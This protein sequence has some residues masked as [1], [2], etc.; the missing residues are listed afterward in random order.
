MN[1]KKLA[2]SI[3]FL[4]FTLLPITIYSVLP[5]PSENRLLD[6]INITVVWWVIVSIIFFLLLSS[7]KL[8]TNKSDRSTLFVIKIYLFW[9]I[10]SMIRGCFIAENYWDWK[11]L[12]LNSQG[13]FAA[14]FAYISC[15]ILMVQTLLRFYV[16][17]VAPLFIIFIPLL[18]NSAY[19]FYLIPFS[20]FLLFLPA[21]TLRWKIIILT[22]AIMVI[23]SDLTARST[24]IRFIVPIILSPIFYLKLLIPNTLLD[25]ARKLLLILPIVLFILAAT[26]TF[27]IFKMD[28][29]IEG[30]YEV[31][32]L[33][34]A[35]WQDSGNLK[36]DT[37]TL[38]YTEVFKSAEKNNSWLIG[39][40]L[41][42]GNESLAFGLNDETGRGERN[43]NE[44]SI[45][46]IFTWTGLVG[47]F[48]YF[49]AFYKASYL[50]INR[51]NNIYVKILGL[52]V[53]FRWVYAW[54]EDFNSFSLNYILLWL[55]IGMCFSK[56][57]RAMTNKEFESWV[58]G[59]FVKR[60]SAK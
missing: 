18:D 54:V 1:K 38:L 16:K 45:L 35:E 24:V 37:R 6:T 33:E 26:D 50:A 56:S 57:F 10:F 55:M 60:L 12:I 20:F 15:S 53:A 42:R 43:G 52:F 47:V 22:I 29:Y 13:L 58:R 39:R 51:S 36:A 44:A 40:S 41:A 14:L 46:N 32:V 25:L 49:M 3:G 19:G 28:D 7:I 9:I 8:L 27:N 48:L 5:W 30:K 2:L 11:F 4:P 21:C 23:F 59:I 31:T 34:T 17:Y